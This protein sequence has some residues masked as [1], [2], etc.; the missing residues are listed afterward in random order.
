MGIDRLS[1]NGS[2]FRRLL[3]A[4][5]GNEKG[6]GGHPANALVLVARSFRDAEAA[7]HQLTLVQAAC[8][9][10]A[11]FACAIMA[12]NASPS[13]IAISARTF[14][15]SSMPASFSPCMNCE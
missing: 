1:P 12:V 13:C 2:G 4:E 10:R 9:G 6:V 3:S 15:S 11:A 14:R 7:R 8:A 5:S